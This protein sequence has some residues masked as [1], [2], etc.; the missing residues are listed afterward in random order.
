M[1]ELDNTNNKDTV[2]SFILW[3]SSNIGFWAH[4]L[5]WTFLNTTWQHLVYQFQI[6]WILKVICNWQFFKQQWADY[7]VAIQLKEND[8]T[9]RIA[10]LRSIM[11]KECLKILQ[12]FQF[13]VTISCTGLY[14]ECTGITCACALTKAIKNSLCVCVKHTACVKIYSL[15]IYFNSKSLVF[16]SIFTHT[17][18]VSLPLESIYL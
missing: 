6:L 15:I 12:T 8:K 14:L 7:E 16:Q 18:M 10:T 13:V 9:V 4:M 2:T 11:C 17:N 3:K 5:N 1:L